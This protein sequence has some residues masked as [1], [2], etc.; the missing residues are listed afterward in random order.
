MGVRDEDVADALARFEGG[1]D[2]VHV[3]VEQR[4]RIDD[5]DVAVPDDVRAG[6]EVG[7]LAR[8][9]G[10]DPAD[11]GRDLVDAPVDDVEVADERDRRGHVKPRGG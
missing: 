5:G 3:G 1:D 4:A 2:G 9:L 6:A 7:E 8:V 11:E 10:H